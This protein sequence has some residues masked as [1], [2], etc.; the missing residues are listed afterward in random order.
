MTSWNV[1]NA[2]IL[3]ASR[4][5]MGGFRSSPGVSAVP[6]IPSDVRS[7]DLVP[8]PVIQTHFSRG[9][10]AS[11][12][13]GS[14]LGPVVVAVRRSAAGFSQT[15][16]LAPRPWPSGRRRSERAP[17]FTSF[18]RRLVSDH[19]ATASG[20]ASV[21]MKLARLVA[22]V[23]QVGIRPQFVPHIYHHVRILLNRDPSAGD[24]P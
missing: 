16:P 15:G 12:R 6:N 18:S 13:P 1:V 23:P 9:D 7:I 11:D 10:D 24:G 3:G 5:A 21:R 14:T 22:C 2:S 8:F 19:C 17:I 4:E 20:K